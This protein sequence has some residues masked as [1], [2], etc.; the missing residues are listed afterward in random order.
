MVGGTVV[1]VTFRESE[2]S[3]LL[4]VQG[5]GCERN[6]TTHVRCKRHR[7][8]AGRWVQPNVGDSVWWQSGKVYWTPAGSRMRD[9]PLE[10]IHGRKA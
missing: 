8:M 9:V 10:K 3:V 2:G 7:T 1:G 4:H 6:D 5:T